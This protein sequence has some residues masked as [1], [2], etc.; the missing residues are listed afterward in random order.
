MELTGGLEDPE[1]ALRRLAPRGTRLRRV[2]YKRGAD[3]GLAYDTVAD[4]F[5]RW[6]ALP[7]TV[8]DPTGAGDAF[9]GGVLA[10]R[11]RGEPLTA[12]IER[13]LVAAAIALEGQGAEALLAAGSEA[14]EARRRAAF[15]GA[16]GAR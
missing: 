6:R 7:A 16:P 14:A 10:G 9:A 5:D 2:L 4:R 13:G 1:A 3:G 8:A 11:L 15:S 12:A